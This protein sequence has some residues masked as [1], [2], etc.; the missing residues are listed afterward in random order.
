MESRVKRLD[1]K[2]SK[3]L[4]I[5]NP[6]NTI[7]QGIPVAYSTFSDSEESETPT[8]IE[9]ANFSNPDTDLLLNSYIQHKNSFIILISL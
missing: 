7:S 2:Y 6:D 4:I 8:L 5:K 3:T 1:Q 9:S